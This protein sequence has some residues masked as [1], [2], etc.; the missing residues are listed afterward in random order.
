[1]LNF[2]IL[3]FAIEGTFI[4][5]NTDWNNH[6]LKVYDLQGPVKSLHQHFYAAIGK[7]GAVIKGKEIDSTEFYAL[8]D[9]KGNI[10][11][12]GEPNQKTTIIFDS[13]GRATTAITYIDNKLF[14]ITTLTYNAKGNL[15]EVKDSLLKDTIKNR[16][17]YTYDAEGRVIG[18][19][20][21]YDKYC[22]EKFIYDKN[23]KVSKAK[24]FIEGRDPWTTKYKY[25]A[26]GNV[27]E[28]VENSISGH[29]HW[30]FEYVYDNKGNYTTR[31]GFQLSS[32][33]PS[34]DE[35]PSNSTT[36][37]LK[38]VEIIERSIEYY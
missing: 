24:C 38:P 26:H 30:Q 34:F 37:R 2:L 13:N 19:A 25:D 1:M 22:V 11:E 5:K 12:E 8:F 27:T 21:K 6:G 16:T 35:L 7:P 31:T 36:T 32:D 33:P 17:S 23:G 29:W 3:L 4:N 15:T 9:S 18:T 14:A 10:I 28:M 20:Y